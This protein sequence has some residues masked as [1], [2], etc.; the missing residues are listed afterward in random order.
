MVKKHGLQALFLTI[1]SQYFYD[2]SLLD[3]HQAYLQD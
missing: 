2:C 1:A 3:P